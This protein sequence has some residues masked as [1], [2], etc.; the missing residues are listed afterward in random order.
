MIVIAVIVALLFGL[1][2]G[3][4]AGVLA[5]AQSVEVHARHRAAER[6]WAD[7][8]LNLRAARR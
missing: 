3:F 8:R 7:G 5:A 6:S 1:A 4:G 2:I